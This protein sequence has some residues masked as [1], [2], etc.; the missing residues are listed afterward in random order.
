MGTP[1]EMRLRGVDICSLTAVQG[2]PDSSQP[3]REREGRMQRAFL[4]VAFL[5]SILTAGCATSM[6]PITN[7]KDTL[8]D[9][10][11]ATVI[12]SFSCRYCVEEILSEDNSLVFEFDPNRATSPVFKL[13]PGRYTV[14]YTAKNYNILRVYRVAK[15]EFKAGHTYNVMTDWCY[16]TSVITSAGGVCLRHKPYT[17][18]I[19]IEDGATGEVLAGEKWY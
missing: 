13:T 2:T 19:W 6:P 9:Q 1:L 3:L 11:V 18:T 12:E 4:W 8:S 15:L 5:A 14:R 7:Y 10:Q 16:A 17:Q